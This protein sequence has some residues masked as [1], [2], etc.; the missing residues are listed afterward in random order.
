M[1]EISS[2]YSRAEIDEN[3]L[4]KLLLESKYG[5]PQALDKLC[6]YAY[7][8]IYY[9]LFYR[10]KNKEDAEDLTSEVVLKMVKGLRNQHG[11][12]RAWIYKIARNALIDYY[13]KIGR[14]QEISYED[15]SHT[16]P[17][18]ENPK[19][20]LMID[21]LKEAITHLTKEQADLITL[22][23]IQEYDNKEIAQ[24]MGKPIGAIKVLQYRALKALR[25]YF[26]KKGYEI[27]D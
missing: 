12:F 25:E 19:E 18:D 3:G 27:K 26:R 8:R 5:N 23:F 1:P 13:R 6:R 2:L 15:L 11:N 10:V 21:R 17:A 16:I 7:S 20:I 14:V 24:I 22:K 4:D 9:Y